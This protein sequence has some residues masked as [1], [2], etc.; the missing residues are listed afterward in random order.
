MCLFLMSPQTKMFELSYFVGFAFL[1]LDIPVL[2]LVA[3]LISSTV[4]CGIE[5]GRRMTSRRGFA[6]N[7]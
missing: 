4:Y 2:A 3:T 7:S 1:Y 6:Q 5:I